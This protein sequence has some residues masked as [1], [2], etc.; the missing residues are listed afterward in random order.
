MSNKFD[1]RGGAG[2]GPDFLSENKIAPF[3]R[4]GPV[5]DL[6]ILQRGRRWNS[7]VCDQT[8]IVVLYG[9]EKSRPIA[10]YQVIARCSCC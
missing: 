4:P 8:G 5:F 3:G 10:R 2:N 1:E 9:W 6:K 7:Q